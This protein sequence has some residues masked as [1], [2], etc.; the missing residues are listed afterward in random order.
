M[1]ALRA[2]SIFLISLLFVIYTRKGCL[3]TLTA[4]KFHII[5]AKDSTLLRCVLEIN[6]TEVMK[7]LIYYNKLVRNVSSSEKFV[8]FPAVSSCNDIF[9]LNGC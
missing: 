8:L 4:C 2:A 9:E 7:L 6:P 1:A 5:L 3:R